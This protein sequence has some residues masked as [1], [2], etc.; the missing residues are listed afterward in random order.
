[1]PGWY[2]Q[3]G[4]LYPPPVSIEQASSEITAKFKASLFQGNSA[5]DLT[6]G[7]GIDSFYLAKRF[8][9]FHY[10]E[11]NEELVSLARHNFEQ[12]GQNNANFHHQTAID[13]LKNWP[14]KVDLIYLDPSRRVQG[15]IIKLENSEPDVIQLMPILLKKGKSIL[16]KSSPL[17]DISDV[18]KRLP[19]V[20]HIWVLAVQNDCKEVLYGLSGHPVEIEISCL[21]FLN[22]SKRQTFTFKPAEE[23]HPISYSLPLTYLYEPNVAVLKAGAFKTIASRFNLPKLHPNSHLYTSN[24]LVS[25]FPGRIFK[26]EESLSFNK[27]ACNQLP[28]QMNVISRNFPASVQQ[29]TRKLNIKEGGEQYLL[30]TMLLSR[31]KRLLYCSRIQ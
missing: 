31:E 23:S 18:I 2:H 25:E 29:I 10:V 26:V 16:I 5:I 4:L 6:G 1:M 8:T 3:P 21:N 7:A 27:K 14:G 17:Q 30:A 9:E 19:R 15:K 28:R 20:N 13:F 11:I 24:Q 22:E 12:L